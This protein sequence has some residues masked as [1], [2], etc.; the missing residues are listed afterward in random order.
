MSNHKYRLGR[1]WL[2]S[3]TEEKGLG[4][5]V[6]EKL[7]MSQKCALATQKAN[8]ILGCIKCGQ[9]VKRGI[10]LIQARMPLAFLVTWAHCWLMF[11][12]LSTNISMSFSAGQPSSHSTPSL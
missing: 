7:S 3:S 4:V 11:S 8:H 6:D 1:E 2:E 12:Q 5:L 9:Q 10:F